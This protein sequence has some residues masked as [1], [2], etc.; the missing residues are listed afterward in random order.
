MAVSGYTAR[1]TITPQALDDIGSAGATAD[2][3]VLRIRVEVSD[4]RDRV[5]LDGYRTRYAPNFL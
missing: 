3:E 1:V 4:G 5:V 2:T